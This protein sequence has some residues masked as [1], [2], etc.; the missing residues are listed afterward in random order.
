ME[1]LS[2]L[3]TLILDVRFGSITDTSLQYLLQSSHEEDVAV[4]ERHRE[5][6]LRLKTAHL[7][8]KAIVDLST[9]SCER[10]MLELPNACFSLP[11][12]TQVM[13]MNIV[14]IVLYSLL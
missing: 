8:Q 10:S 6:T 13:I 3:C 4:R 2:D 9:P 7:D 1:L 14:F 5:H 12:L 11:I